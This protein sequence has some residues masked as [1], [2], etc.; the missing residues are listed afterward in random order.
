QREYFA[1]AQK[2]L[3][4]RDADT[5][6]VLTTWQQV[7]DDLERDPMLCRDRLDW[8][9]KKWLLDTFVAAE[10]LRWDDPWLQ[11]LD[12]EY[13]NV[14]CDEGLYAELVRAGNMQLFVTGDD[15]RNAI[16]HPPPDT[17]A[18]FRGKCV[19]KFAKQMTADQWDDLAF[20]VG[21]HENVVRQLNVFDD[22]EVR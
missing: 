11:S 9:A 4:G 16:S 8:V 19:E 6:W 17:R 20:E 7:L 2:K 12:L 18:Y 22:D 10:D 5:D 3:R 21:D 15:I 1:T 14:R 13:H